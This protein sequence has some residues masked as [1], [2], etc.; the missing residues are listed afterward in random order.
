MLAQ[1]DILEEVVILPLPATSA[2][3][4]QVAA[5]LDAAHREGLVHRDIKPENLLI[6]PSG[7]V[8]LSDFGIS[9][10]MDADLTATGQVLGTPA[11]MAPEQLLGHHL[12]ARTDLFALGA[13]IY[14]CLTGV[15][16][17]FADTLAGLTYKIVHVDPRPPQL[18]NPELT[19]ETSAVVQRCLAKAPE[20]RYQTGQELASALEETAPADQKALEQVV[21]QVLERQ[22]EMSG[23]DLAISVPSGSA[24]G[25]LRRISQVA[26]RQMVGSWRHRPASLLALLLVVLILAISGLLV[27]PGNG[28]DP[29]LSPL[30]SKAS[31]SPPAPR[32]L[33]NRPHC[34]SRSWSSAL[35]ID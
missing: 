29:V 3:V 26:T 34:P 17:F 11:Y 22:E 25:G 30:P 5:A 23:D 18:H 2:I 15:T 24:I 14:R 31:W 20:D 16:P 27:W 32:L 35:R 8:K 12:D 10:H 28:I 13:V 33:G 1:G 21:R 19:D 7:S 4:C 6:E 9:R